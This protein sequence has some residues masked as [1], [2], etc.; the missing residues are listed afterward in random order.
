MNMPESRQRADD[1]AMWS[2]LGIYALVWLLG[3]GIGLG[4]VW[5][6]PYCK[7]PRHDSGYPTARRPVGWQAR[8]TEARGRLTEEEKEWIR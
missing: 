1:F 7:C 4:G 8:N 3:L 2:A 5:D 6:E